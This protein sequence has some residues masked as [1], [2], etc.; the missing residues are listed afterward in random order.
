MCPVMY[1]WV[2]VC[3]GGMAFYVSRVFLAEVEGDGG[4]CS[5]CKRGDGCVECGKDVCSVE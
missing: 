2:G 5:S 3:V 1:V 4:G